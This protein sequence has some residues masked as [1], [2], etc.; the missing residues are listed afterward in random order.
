MKKIMRVTK[1]TIKSPK[2]EFGAFCGR[3]SRQIIRSPQVHVF[4]VMVLIPNLIACLYFS[5]LATNMYVS[6]ANFVVQHVSAKIANPLDAVMGSV[7]LSSNSSSHDALI[8]QEYINSYDML[9]KLREKF[10]I[11]NLYSNKSFD[12]YSRLKKNPTK[13]EFLEYYKSLV[14]VYFDPMSGVVNIEFKSYTPE[15]SKLILDEILELSED[16]IERLSGKARED[17]LDFAKKEVYLAE[18]RVKNSITK[19]RNFREDKNDLD[20][21]SSAGGMMKILAEFETEKLKTEAD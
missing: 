16:L 15:L 1:R 21:A 17:S 5:F 20:P 14:K 3:L 10:D 18:E 7:G 9:D 11:K 12:F 19:L 4:I 2:K 13:E 6:K 8:V